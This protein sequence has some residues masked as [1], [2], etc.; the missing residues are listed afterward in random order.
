[1]QNHSYE[2]GFFFF[3]FAW[4]CTWSGFEKEAKS[5]SEMGYC[6]LVYIYCNLEKW[7]LLNRRQII[8]YID[9]V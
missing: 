5:N 9:N 8:Q 7:L 2:N 6:N 1:M 3:I 4:F